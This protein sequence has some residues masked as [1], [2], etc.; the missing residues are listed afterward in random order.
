VHNAALDLRFHDLRIDNRADV[1][2]RHEADQLDLTRISVDFDEG[3][4]SLLINESICGI[5]P[6]YK[7][8]KRIN[9]DL[10]ERYVPTEG[11]ANETS[12]FRI[13]AAYDATGGA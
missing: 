9:S 1:L 11:E 3:G 12:C 5:Y 13:R 4:T 8:I 6:S 7:I 10:P 2:G